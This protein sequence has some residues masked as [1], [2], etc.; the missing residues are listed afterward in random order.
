[1]SDNI[2]SDCIIT[3]RGTAMIS[4]R[5]QKVDLGWGRISQR[6][7]RSE[8]GGFMGICERPCRGGICQKPDRSN[9][10]NYIYI[11]IRKENSLSDDHCIIRRGSS[12]IHFGGA[13]GVGV[14]EGGP[15]SHRE[16]FVGHM[17]K[18]AVFDIKPTYNH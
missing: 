13:V 8:P 2:M 17:Y 18:Y 10:G 11:Y 3:M 15:V 1:M 9:C 5:A 7:I 4:L 12:H 6:D 14:S 16:E